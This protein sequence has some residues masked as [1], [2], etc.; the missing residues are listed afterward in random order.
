MWP[1]ITVLYPSPKLPTHAQMIKTGLVNSKIG[2]LCFQPLLMQYTWCFKWFIKIWEDCVAYM[3]GV[4]SSSDQYSLGSFGGWRILL[5]GYNPVRL[6]CI[7][8]HRISLHLP[9]PSI[10][11]TIKQSNYQWWLMKDSFICYSLTNKL[12]DKQTLYY[13]WTS[14][15]HTALKHTGSVWIKHLKLTQWPPSG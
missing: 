9:F 8:Y 2:L 5:F 14:I 4:I 3:C 10:A 12:L 15:K 11:F 13:R 7:F 6:S 1:V